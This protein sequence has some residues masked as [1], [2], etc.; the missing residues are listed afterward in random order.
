MIYWVLGRRKN[1]NTGINKYSEGYI[2]NISE[3]IKVVYV[4]SV[5]EGWL[6][7]FGKYLYLPFYLFLKGFRRNKK[8]IVLPD[9]SFSFLYYFLI[10]WRHRYIIV[11]DYRDV[12]PK[13]WKENVKA[14]LM[15][16]NYGMLF[17]YDKIITVSEYTREVIERKLKIPNKKIN[18]IYNIIDF[19]ETNLISGCNKNKYGNK[20]IFLYVGSHES[21]KNTELLVR[22]FSQLPHLTLIMAGKIID[23]SNNMKI[24]NLI[25]NCNN[26]YNLGEVD[27]DELQSLYYTANY[28]ICVSS[29]E[30]FGRTPVEA[31][32]YK[33]PVL[34]TWN[35]GLCE[36]LE[37][38]SFYLIRE[39][40]NEVSIKTAISDFLNLSQE[41]INL[42]IKNGTR[43]AERFSSKNLVKKM[44]K[45]IQ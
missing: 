7:P 40:L 42:F 32:L 28:F 30:G 15:R 43:N 24:N 20:T 35:T 2:K 31:Q 18:V 3:N 23:S 4:P 8:D 5:F 25:K 19:D 44:E 36:V 39:P 12:E 13:T 17:K 14:I 26:I 10:N 34:S 6:Y 1:R 33:L 41:E 9:E 45:I 27:S 37:K 22:V 38:G 21:R 16:F 29:F 11:H